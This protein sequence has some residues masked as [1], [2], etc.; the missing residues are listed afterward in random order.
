MSEPDRHLP[1][2]RVLDAARLP[3]CLLCRLVRTDT[4][5]YIESVLYE[6][7]NDVG[8]RA[9]WRASR[10]FCHRHAWILAEF[11]DALGTAILYEDLIRHYGDKLLT[12]NAGTQ[13]PL[14]HAERVNL[15]DRLAVL[16]QSWDDQELRAAVEA[17]DGLCGPHLRALLRQ[18]RRRELRT[19][20]RRVSAQRLTELAER[21]RQQI[22]SFDY[23]HAGGGDARARDAWQ[24]AIERVVGMRD[25]PEP[26]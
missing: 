16:E 2:F 17:G 19:T 11:Q 18:T 8:F 9:R 26:H 21:L 12:A 4:R 14:C 5:R 13:C 6:S 3:G 15:R 24:R 25:V 10:G 1:F 7:V 22:Q 20:F 23:R